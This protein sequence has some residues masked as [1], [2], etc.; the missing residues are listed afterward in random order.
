MS[1]ERGQYSSSEPSQAVTVGV[2]LGSMLVFTLGIPLGILAKAVLEDRADRRAREK[3]VRMWRA[4]NPGLPWSR[5][6]VSAA[7]RPRWDAAR[8]IW[9]RQ[10]PHS[11]TGRK[12]SAK[13]WAAFP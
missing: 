13:A 2:I 4:E 7:Q 10:Y 5:E 9:E 3:E 8:W 11:M 12:P 6:Q 1:S